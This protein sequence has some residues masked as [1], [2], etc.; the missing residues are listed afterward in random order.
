MSVVVRILVLVAIALAQ[1]CV[2]TAEEIPRQGGELVFVV[3]AEPPS[4][5][6]HREETFAMLH[7]VAPSYNTLLRTDPTERQAH[8]HVQASPQ[9]EV[10][11][12]QPDDVR[13]REGVVRPHHFPPP[14][15]VSSRQAAYR[16][17]EA[18]ETPTPDTVVFR[19][20]W[21]EGSFIANLSSPWNWIYKAE[22][23]AKDPCWYEKNVMG[24]GPFKF[25]EYVRGSHW[26]GKKNTDYWDKGKPY[27]DG[28]R[29][30]FIRDPA[31]QV[32]A[33][34]GERAMAAVPW[35][36]AGGARS[37][38]ERPRQQDHRAGKPVELL[39]PGGAE[40][41]EE[42]V[43]RQ[44]GAPGAVAGPR[45]LG[46]LEGTVADRSGEGG[47]RHPGAGDAVGTAAP[48]SS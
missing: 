45:P 37:A 32:S 9:R 41:A 14:G 8:V 40:S 25:V 22:I 5:D 27:L 3:P 33:I 13:G 47:R 42:A 6:G 30:L 34:R 19:L 46:R 26:V 10:P 11:R 48:R 20:K 21:Y 28:Y 1:W 24:T 4:F 18:V 38:R 29:I 16:L 12:R 31:A 23:L 39:D 44:A 43:R 7:P 17:V 35:L 2:V 15:V 36:L